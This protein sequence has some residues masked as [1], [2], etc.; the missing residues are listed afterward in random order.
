MIT[1]RDFLGTSLASTLGAAAST[2]WSAATLGDSRII[3]A[4]A[5]VADLR[6]AESA[7]FATALAHGG[8]AVHAFAGDVTRVWLN[9]LEPLWRARQAAVAGLTSYSTLF[10]LE[11]LAWDHG[12]RVVYRSRHTAASDGT[13]EHA[14]PQ[15]AGPLASSLRSHAAGE[16]PLQVA[17]W[18]ARAPL[19][20]TASANAGAA[21]LRITAH[22][23]GAARTPPLYAWLI[24]LPRRA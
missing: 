20:S 7:A 13:L 2:T 9:D 8:V 17:A 5:A 16:W 21:G 3:R 22:D 11:R 18:L 10:C 24:A 12:M 4:E 19:S 1:R 15:T 14:L 23:P 6:F